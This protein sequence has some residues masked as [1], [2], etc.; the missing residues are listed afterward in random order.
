M[1][2]IITDTVISKTIGKA[3][4]AVDILIVETEKKELKQL[5]EYVSGIYPNC[6]IHSFQDG[7]KALEFAAGQPVDICFTEIDTGTS[8]GF[9]LTRVVREKNK[10]ALINLI[11]DCREYALDAWKLH[12]NDYLLKPIT[13]ESILHTR[14]R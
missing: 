8:S 1:G 3:G 11:S 10:G 6:R 9:A 5:C 14:C 12:V 7:Q 4:T 2:I 13:R